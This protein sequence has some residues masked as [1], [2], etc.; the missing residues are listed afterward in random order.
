MQSSESTVINNAV[1]KKD[2]QP[3]EHFDWSF[4][5]DRVQRRTQE[6]LDNIEHTV[7]TILDEELPNAERI[8]R[9]I[10]AKMDSQRAMIQAKK[11][12][13]QYIDD[14]DDD[15]VDGDE[16]PLVVDHDATVDPS[17]PDNV[18]LCDKSIILFVGAENE[19][20]RSDVSDCL[21]I[22]QVAADKHLSDYKLRVGNGA[23]YLECLKEWFTKFTLTFKACGWVDTGFSVDEATVKGSD[24]SVDKVL[25]DIIDSVA[26][27]E[28][29]SKCLKAIEALRKLPTEDNRLQLFNQR[30][31]GRDGGQF[32]IHMIYVDKR[33]AATMKTTMIGLSTT[34]T[35][36]NVLWFNWRDG[37]TKLYKTEHQM[38]LG[39]HMY[40]TMR[41]VVSARIKA[42][43][44]NY[45]NSIPI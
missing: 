24:A 8:N 6:L 2:R 35:V 34:L 39:P 37:N 20:V 4:V 18:L 23:T 17:K 38:M 22:S 26:N 16:Q 31:I 19:S 9:M 41:G 11:R 7:M 44:E 29:K 28:E 3:T 14:N 45:I 27:E 30:T 15:N 42:I 36:T 13:L 5:L 33:G 25:I 10:N 32:L 21:L 43:N 40:D 1:N 12:R